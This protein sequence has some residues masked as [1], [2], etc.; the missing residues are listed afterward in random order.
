MTTLAADLR[1]FVAAI[2][3]ELRVVRRYPT[4]WMGLIFWPVLLPAS[5]VLM[6]QAFS[7]SDPRS[8]AAF[9]E[10]SGTA[11][12]A[13]FV[14]VGFAMYMWL[15]TI[16][17]G[18]G[19]ALRTEQMR[20]SLEAVFLTPTSRL[21]ALFGPPAA[22]LPTLVITFVV[23]GLAMWLIYGVAL[24]LDGVLRSLVVVAFALP[25]LYAIGALFA[26][27]V[28]RFGEIGP[29]V[30]LVRGVLVLTCGIT[31][32]VLMLP[33]WAQAVAAV[34]PPTYIVQDIRGVLL[35]G[36]GIGDV[37]VDL[38][39]TVGLSALLAA[40]AIVTFRVL[41]ASARRNGMLGR[42]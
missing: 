34:L 6:G 7:G 22:A 16:L 5:Y 31:F 35:R 11:E 38:L 21:V 39:I 15:S 37:A 29:I 18:P 26:A 27:G 32:P 10:R 41:E 9:A 13:G 30:Q 33:G 25:S 40:F 36:L 2:R 42:Y 19:T 28:L 8:I 4:Q 3:K 23:M 17:W 14:F 20:G 1:A 12:V 24:P